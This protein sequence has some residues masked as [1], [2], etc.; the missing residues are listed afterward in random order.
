MRWCLPAAD[1]EEA[2][3]GLV[4]FYLC[5]LAALP[6]PAVIISF[7]RKS[8][9]RLW[10]LFLPSFLPFRSLPSVRPFGVCVC[11]APGGW[12]FT[13]SFRCCFYYYVIIEF[14]CK[15][16]Q[17]GPHRSL[18]LRPVVPSCPGPIFLLLRSF[19]SE[20]GCATSRRRFPSVWLPFALS[21]RNRKAL[22]VGQFLKSYALCIL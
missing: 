1:V 22:R 16:W 9:N 12:P 7:A 18:R 20:K 21:I 15:D 6:L 13:A 17:R 5:F 10:L 19:F 3:P 4:V 11:S 14:I 2:G 8:G